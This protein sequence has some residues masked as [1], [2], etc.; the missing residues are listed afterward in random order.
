VAGRAGPA[1]WRSRFRVG[2]KPPLPAGR[3]GARRR[4]RRRPVPGCSLL[5]VAALPGVPALPIETFRWSVQG[6]SEDVR[7][8]GWA[9]AL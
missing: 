8:R 5:K 2:G 6:G 7:S 3:A 9:G 4:W 1:L